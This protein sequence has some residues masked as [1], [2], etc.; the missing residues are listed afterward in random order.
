M[1]DG[2]RRTVNLRTLRLRGV[3]LLVLPFFWLAEPTW[4]SLAAGAPLTLAGLFLRAWA[5]GH[6]RKEETLAAGGPYAFVRN[7]L[8]LGSLLVGV[9]LTIAG[10]HWIW[11]A[12][13][14]AF[15]VTAY[16]PTAGEEADRL[17]RLFGDRYRD[18]SAEVPAWLPRRTSYRAP[19]H[20]ARTRFA[21]RR[22]SRNREWE[23][24]LGG[25]A[26]LGILALRAWLEAP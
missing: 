14:V 3:W 17:T 22:Y 7:P 21:W 10:G 2:A 24:L 18:Y 16:A 19:D 1:P 11:P 26:A 9:G 5:A 13:F 12:L 4:P 25:A 6:I 23:A 8:Y 15:F 20:E